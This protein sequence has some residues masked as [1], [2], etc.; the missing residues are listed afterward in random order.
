MHKINQFKIMIK[1]LSKQKKY[2]SVYVNL[3]IFTD[4]LL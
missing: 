4:K 2:Y 1:I 3:I